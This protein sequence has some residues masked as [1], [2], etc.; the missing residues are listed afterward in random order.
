[1]AVSLEQEFEWAKTRHMFNTI[2]RSVVQYYRDTQEEPDGFLAAELNELLIQ[3]KAARETAEVLLC[4]EKDV[5]ID[6]YNKAYKMVGTPD[7]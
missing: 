1:M 2:K 3:E 5:F 4:N 6:L 7:D